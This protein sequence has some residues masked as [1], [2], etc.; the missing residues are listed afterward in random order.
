MKSKEPRIKL[1]E[2]SFKAVTEFATDSIFIADENSTILYCNKKALELFGYQQEEIIGESLTILMP[3]RHRNAHL[4]GIKRFINSGQSTL[5][6]KTF[7]ISA[8]HKNQ[9]EFPIE[10][11]LSAWT[12]K[13]KYYFAGII[14]NTSE[15][16]KIMKEMEIL[17]TISASISKADNFNN[18][19]SLTI[20]F[21]CQEAG[22]NC[23]EAWVLNR[24]KYIIEYA[25]VWYMSEEKFLPFFEVS[26][27][28]TFKIGEGM[29]GSVFLNKTVWNPDITSHDSDFK[30]KEIAA[31]VGL[32]S[33]LGVPIVTHEGEVFASL[34]FYFTE[35]KEEDIIFTRVVTSLA[36][37]LGT[38]LEK[39]QTEERLKQSRDFY[40]TILED[41]PALIW[42][43]NADGA[44]V[45]YNKTWLKFSGSC[46]EDELKKDWSASIP[47]EDYE[48]LMTTFD[49]ASKNKSAFEI[50]LR[51]KRYDGQYRWILS[52]GR[53]FYDIDKNFKGYLGVSYDI[54]DQKRNISKLNQSNLELQKTTEELMETEGMLHKLNMEL[55]KKVEARTKDLNEK[56]DSLLKINTDL[57]NFIYTASHDLK[58]PIANIEGLTTMLDDVTS[59][60]TFK[61][62]EVISLIEMIK[63]SISKLKN[64]IMDLTE[65]SKIQRMEK[66]DIAP[67][68]LSEIIDDVQILLFDQIKKNNAEISL[69]LENC[70]TIEFSK[71]DLRS[72]VMNLLSNAIKYR[73][74][75][76]PEV[77]IKCYKQDNYAILSVSDNGIGIDLKH[78][79]LFKM[80]KRFNTE[81]E[82]TGI[83][84]YIIKRIIDDAGGKI[85]VESEKGKGSTFSVYFKQQ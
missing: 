60:P 28:A 49:N 82:G 5:I 33:A 29:T 24:G 30:R 52:L 47:K 83:G 11:S 14:R 39:K 22:W 26:K 16:H 78:T 81:T 20:K 84:L 72:I 56:N 40:L 31:Q 34:M 2:N 27:L 74:E 13:G 7:E 19:L 4:K 77:S 36:I 73:S 21:I 41:F 48:R 64:T 79:K 38:F 12:E 35:S 9:F 17:Q 75:R 1:S 65:I 53:P 50:E 71:K 6:G 68:N 69:N 51:V 85:E 46:L 63:T 57:D 62:K 54:T 32:K 18:A 23:G 44:P 10:L 61:K 66:D 80:F 43:T 67:Q 8:I 59:D 15:K 25:P 76:T 37:Q 70:P 3:Q 55:E 58:A 45:Y 42:R